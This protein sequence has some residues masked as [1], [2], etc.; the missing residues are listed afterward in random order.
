METFR[1]ARSCPPG[2]ARV[3]KTIGP[4]GG[5]AKRCRRIENL[6]ATRPM[7]VDHRNGLPRGPRP[8]PQTE[9]DEPPR[10]SAPAWRRVLALVLGDVFTTTFA[11]LAK[12]APG[13][14]DPSF[15]EPPST[16]NGGFVA[17]PR[18]TALIAI[19]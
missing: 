2:P 19:V 18:K 16:Q 13:Y 8:A 4:V 10:L 1:A 17:P 9:N 6:G 11:L 12:D 15:S 5:D 7:A 3:R 14:R